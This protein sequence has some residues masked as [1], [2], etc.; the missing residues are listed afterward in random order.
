DDP[1]LNLTSV[2]R[3][4]EPDLLDLADFLL[5]EQS[6]VYG[7]DRSQRGIADRRSCNLGWHIGPRISC[8]ERPV[9]GHRE[10]DVPRVRRSGSAEVSGEPPQRAIE[11]I[12]A[13]LAVSLIIVGEEDSLAVGRPLRV[14]GVAVEGI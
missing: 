5:G 11:R 8:G 12:E 4:V 13:E 6:P 2:L 7:C 14:S 9:P 3:G 1:A 10:R